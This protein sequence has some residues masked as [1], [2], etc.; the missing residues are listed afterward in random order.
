MCW[1]LVTASVV[2]SAPILATLM[3]EALS[4]SE[5]SVL[6]R[7]TRR[8]IQENAI[9]RVPFDFTY[10]NK[11]TNTMELCPAC[12]AAS[13]IAIQELSNI[14]RNWNIHYHVHRNLPLMPAHHQINPIHTT[15]PTK[16]IL[17]EY[18]HLAFTQKCYIHSSPTPHVLHALPIS[19]FLT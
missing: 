2:P 15:L 1:L 7:A 14:L 12:D 11:L 5:T 6:T 8:N 18:F 3:K 9:L 17:A 13:C 19:S 16:V 10:L 4:S